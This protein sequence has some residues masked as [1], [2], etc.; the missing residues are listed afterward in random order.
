MA[1]GVKVRLCKTRIN[2]DS[3]TFMTARP[4]MTPLYITGR[5][6]FT[7]SRETLDGFC[8]TVCNGALIYEL[9]PLPPLPV[10]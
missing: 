4:I 1:E 3:L 7:V 10:M 5:A 9:P 6:M 2:Q 8:K